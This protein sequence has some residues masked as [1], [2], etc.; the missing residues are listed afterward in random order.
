[1]QKLDA[2]KVVADS[3]GLVIQFSVGGLNS[4]TLHVSAKIRSEYG[5][6]M[7]WFIYGDVHEFENPQGGLGA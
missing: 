7:E 5:C 3:V 2:W 1:M 4:W 6:K